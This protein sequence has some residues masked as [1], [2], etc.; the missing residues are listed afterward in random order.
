M[1][2][3]G[4]TIWFSV[5]EQQR[6]LRLEN[7]MP[8]DRGSYMDDT[9]VFEFVWND[10]TK[11]GVRLGPNGHGTFTASN[12]SMRCEG[13]LTGVMHRHGEILEASGDWGPDAGAQGWW[14]QWRAEFEL[15]D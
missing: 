7:E 5:D 3:V 12:R 8:I 10:G 4:G 11:Y 1:R 15:D 14:G 9:A 6:R 2:I 13:K